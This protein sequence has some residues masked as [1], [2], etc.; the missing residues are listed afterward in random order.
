MKTTPGSA[1]LTLTPALLAEIQAE[2]GEQHRPAADVLRDIVAHG[3]EE[4]RWQR[5][6][7]IKREDILARVDAAELSLAKR[8]G[9]SITE[10]SMRRLAEDVKQRGRARLDAENSVRR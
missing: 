2:A 10:A 6:L 4:M 7:A 9:A 5:T 3:L 8:E 1:G